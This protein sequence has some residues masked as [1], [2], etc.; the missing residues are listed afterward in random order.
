MSVKEHAVA[1]AGGGPTGLMLAA[2]LA[3]AKVDVVVVER[4]PDHALAGSRAGGFHSRT[5]ELLDQRG[6]VDRFLAEGQTAQVATFATTTLDMSDFPTRHPYSLGIWQSE[7]E[8]IM[9]AWIAELPV[10]VHYA[11]EVTG[12]AQNDAGV[13]VELSDGGSL[14]A[15]YLVGCDGGRSLIRKAAAIEFPGWEATRSSLI[16]EAEML[17]QPELGTRHD[18]A[19]VHGIGRLEYEIRD[20][21]VVYADEGPVR[22]LITEREIGSAGEP[23]LRELSDALVGVYGTDFGVHSPT[24]MSRFTDATRQAATSR[25]GRVLLAGDAAH[26]H[27]PA[28]GQGLSLGLQDAVN[29][30]WKLAQVVAGVS[31]QSLLDS[32]HAERHPVVARALRYTMAQTV[33]QRRDERTEALTG[34]LSEVVGM[35]EPRKLLAGLVSGLDIRYDLGE[36][37]PLLGRRMPDLDLVTADGPLRV[38][39][40]LHDARPLL[41]DLGEA[42]DFDI[43][44]WDDRVRL[45]DAERAGQWELPVIGVVPPPT[46]VLVRPDGYVAWV[47]ERRADAGLTDA[48]TAWFGP[49]RR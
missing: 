41:L 20:G 48:L 33:L 28:G 32:Y 7:I 45:V 37:H 3:L 30:G 29:L 36:G 40:L 6:I 35:D 39:E 21:E 15:Q 1:I 17:E 47:G 49:A 16:A 25:S 8:R 38:F 5:I 18:A 34:L 46:G 24:W 43:A 11:R 44:P 27:Y 12:F 2:E 26:V 42:G 4:R 13:E 23:T 14:R 22:V 19:G 9:A 31:P 10:Q